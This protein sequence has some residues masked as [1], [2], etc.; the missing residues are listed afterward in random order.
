MTEENE[1]QLEDLYLDDLGMCGCGTPRDVQKLL[2]DLLNNS[3]QTE[4]RVE[5]AREI[6]KNTDPDT[7]FE[8]IF[9]ILEDKGFIEHGTSVYSSWLSDKGKTFLD[10]LNEINFDKEEEE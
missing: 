5:K 1:K 2:K 8:F 3:I 10:L 4:N 6:I 9:H 7:I